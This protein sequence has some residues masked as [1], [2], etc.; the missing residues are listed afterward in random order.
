MGGLVAT[1]LEK[2]QGLYTGGEGPVNCEDIGSFADSVGLV[3][4]LSLDQCEV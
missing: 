4:W 1:G 3:S 2:D